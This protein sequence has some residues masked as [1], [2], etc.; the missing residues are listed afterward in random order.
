MRKKYIDDRRPIEASSSRKFELEI[1]DLGINLR[2]KITE[3]EKLYSKI[4]FLK[5]EL[6]GISDELFNT[7]IE[8]TKKTGHLKNS[9][10]QVDKLQ[11]KIIIF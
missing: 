5:L 1:E 3:T 11:E 7:K 2:L 6:S 9:S 10:D 8:L 4:K